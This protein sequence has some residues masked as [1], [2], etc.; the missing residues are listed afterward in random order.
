[1]L[2]CILYMG[3]CSDFAKDLMLTSQEIIRHAETDLEKDSSLTLCIVYVAF[4]YLMRANK[5]ISHV[6]VHE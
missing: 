5:E 4:S 1:M 3:N 6:I 2:L